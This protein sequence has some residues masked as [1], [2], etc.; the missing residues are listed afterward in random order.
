MYID[1]R[2]REGM[3]KSIAVYLDVSVDELY[4]YIDFAA[5]KAQQD[6]C[7]FNT[8]IFFD[9]L[10]TIISDLQP[11]LEIDEL[12]FFH[13]SRRLHGTEDDV[14]GRNLENLFTTGNALS[15]FLREHQIE[16]VKGTQN[17]ITYYKGREVDWGKCW[18][19]NSAYMKS[20]LGYFKGREDYCFNG[21][22]FKDLLYKNQYA[23]ILCD[24]PEIIGQ[25]AECLGCKDVVCDYVQ[26][27]SYYCYEYKI[28]I[29]RVMFDDH[30]R[31]SCSEKQR[32][33]VNCVLERLL[34]YSG[35]TS[36]RYMFDHDNPILRLDDHDILPAEFFV[37]KE[38]ITAD[39]LRQ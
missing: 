3:E 35:A 38:L 18:N 15:D 22:A 37:Q 34:Q 39:M 4:Q 2:S 12:F 24:V 1:T 5:E 20:R 10:E 9:E 23:R 21:F 25:L 16:F 26:N 28:P 30:D 6:Q 31:Y 8:D 17:I 27:S 19:G 29:D 7:A 36:T 32:Y 14:S 33:L 11:E 13:L